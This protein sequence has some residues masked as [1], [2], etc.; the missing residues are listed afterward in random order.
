MNTLKICLVESLM[1]AYPY[2]Q[3]GVSLAITWLI[4]VWHKNRIKF[5]NN[6][7]EAECTVWTAIWRVSTRQEDHGLHRS[8]EPH[9]LTISKLEHSY[10]DTRIYCMYTGKHSS[11][12]CFGPFHPYRQW[13]NFE[14]G[15]FVYMCCWI[16]NQPFWANFRGGEYNLKM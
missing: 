1:K 2:M 8:P 15:E 7:Q 5:I 13:A 16:V 10:D 3:K 11:P 4:S 6:Y 9:C 14:L 12:F